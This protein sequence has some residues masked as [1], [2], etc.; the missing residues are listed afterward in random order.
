MIRN[1]LCKA[2]FSFILLSLICFSGDLA[3]ANENQKMDI[4]TASLEELASLKGIGEKKAQS[5]VKY[6]HNND[7]FMT[8][9][10]LKNVNGIGDKL[11]ERIKGEIEVKPATE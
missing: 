4:N 2:C 9:D 6:R 1:F 3:T 11:F 10:E 5:I 8:I 7:P